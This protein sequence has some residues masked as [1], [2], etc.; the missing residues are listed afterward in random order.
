MSSDKLARSSGV[1]G[2]I[3]LA[4]VISCSIAALPYTGV[5][6]SGAEWS[7]YLV[8][9]ESIKLRTRSLIKYP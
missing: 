9:N 4:A 6:L 1:L 5:N 8:L 7:R 3:A 2:L